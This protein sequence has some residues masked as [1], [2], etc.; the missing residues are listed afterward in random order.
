MDGKIRGLGL[1]WSATLGAFAAP[2][3]IAV[4]VIASELLEGVAVNWNVSV[5][6]L[7]GAPPSLLV[8]WLLGMPLVLYLRKKN[9]LNAFAVCAG[10]AAIGAICFAVLLWTVSLPIDKAA[11]VPEQ[12]LFGALL[13][14]MVALACCLLARIPFRTRRVTPSA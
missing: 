2:A 13:G 11:Q 9:Q 5:I 4:E 8:T 7:F 14:L 6:F 3:A 10:G 1:G 12:A